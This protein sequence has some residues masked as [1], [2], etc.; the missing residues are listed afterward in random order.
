[1]ERRVDGG[2]EEKK[3]SNIS[4]REKCTKAKAKAKRKNFN[5]SGGRKP[6][7]RFQIYNEPSRAK[8]EL[9]KKESFSRASTHTR[10]QKG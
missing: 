10:G 1:V 4:G 2:T 7:F 8:A 5:E 9:V 3:L 6:V